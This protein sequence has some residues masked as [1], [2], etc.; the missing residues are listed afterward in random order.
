VKHYAVNAQETGRVMVSSDMADA[1]LRESD[2]LA[3]KIA[4]EIGKP[5]TVMPGYNLINGNYAS[6]NAFLINTVL[7]GDWKYPAGSCLTGAQPID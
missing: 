5:G 1:A 7:K 2:L 3:F 4:L 6:E